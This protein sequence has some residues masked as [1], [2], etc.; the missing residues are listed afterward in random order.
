MMMIRRHYTVDILAMML[1]ATCLQWQNSHQA[2][3]KRW[4]SRSY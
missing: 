3:H 1:T 4:S 2:P